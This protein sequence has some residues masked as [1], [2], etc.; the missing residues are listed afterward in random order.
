MRRMMFGVIAFSLLVSAPVHAGLILKQVQSSDDGGRS[1]RTVSEMRIE[2]GKTRID[3]LE[4][5]ENPYFQPGAYMLFVNEDTAY[6]VNPKDRTYSRM[7]LEE[8]QNVGRT[9]AQ[10]EEQMHRQGGSISV[11][12][13]NIRKK[14]DEPG[15]TMLG[16]PTEHVVYDVTYT[17]PMG[18]QSGPMTMKM[19][20]HETYEIW[21]TRDLEKELSGAAAFKK[22][23][24][25]TGFPGGSA[26]LAQVGEA[27]S[28]H[29]MA[30]KMIQ[31]TESKINLPGINVLLGR[32]GGSSQ[33]SKSTT[34]VTA[35]RK[36]SLSPDLFALPDGYTEVDLSNPNAGAMP[37][38]NRI[39]GGPGPSGGPGGTSTPPM[40]DL[41]KMP[42]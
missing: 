35:L 32:P 10:S 27:L 29:G 9:A 41:D 38:L 16:F 20:N 36:E 30:L 37:D 22:R 18:M 8:M 6:I 28:R 5:V 31:T 42:K 3:F 4:T 25:G 39:P 34:E 14:L 19:E 15:P 21:A 26:A 13:L 12:D 40:P 24:P 17:R 2:G 7:D 1:A 11:E 23:A 33:R